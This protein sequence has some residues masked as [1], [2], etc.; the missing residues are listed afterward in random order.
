MPENGKMNQYYSFAFGHAH[1][2]IISTEDPIEPGT[3][4]H[5]WFHY[6]LGHATSHK[7]GYLLLDSAFVCMSLTAMHLRK[8]AARLN[9]LSYL[10]T[11]RLGHQ[12]TRSGH[13]L[14]HLS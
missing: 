14:R 13:T 11:D 10:A 12:A 8:I 4:Q 2:T 1:I 6:D 5:R 9:G 3:S 7:F